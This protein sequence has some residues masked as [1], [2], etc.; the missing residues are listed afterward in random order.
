MDSKRL[1]AEHAL[2]GLGVFGTARALYALTSSGKRA[3]QDRI[4]NRKFYS[5][6]ISSG[7]LVF[8]IGANLGSYADIF[9]SLGA[10]VVAVEPNPDCVS[11]IRRS[12]PKKSINVINAAVGQDSGLGT[13][14]LAKRSD[15]SS[16]SEDW[17]RAIQKAQN[18]EDSIWENELTVP[19]I[20]LN[21]LIAKY[22]V[23]N[24]IKIDVEGL[25]EAVLRGLSVQPPLLSFE[26]NTNF[27]DT[28]LRCTQS[29]PAASHCLFNFA[30][31]EP[32]KLEL[33]RW[34]DAEQLCFAL[35][36]LDPASGY[37][38]VFVRMEPSS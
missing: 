33:E 11:H 18:L 5:Q 32:Q 30:L 35:K 22:G 29:L 28:A 38:D 31:G 13:I 7:D 1:R 27:L 17:I 9:A 36:S 26:F 4:K 23:P 6:F 10:L 25:E 34:V 15:M 12:Y 3:R 19:V 8:D 16:M 14:R 37:G 20:T 2:Y 24:F 21:S